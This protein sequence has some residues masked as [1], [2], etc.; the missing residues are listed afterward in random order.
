MPKIIKFSRHEF[1]DSYQAKNDREGWL[2]T[3]RQIADNF[4]FKTEAT[5][6][7]YRKKFGLSRNKMN[8]TCTIC[9]YEFEVCICGGVAHG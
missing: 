4:G 9:Q 3:R 6:N 2:Y 8:K 7:R 5:V 1:V